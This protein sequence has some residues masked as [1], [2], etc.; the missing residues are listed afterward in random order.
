[1]PISP[2]CRLISWESAL[3]I[4]SAGDCT[5]NVGDDPPCA[6]FHAVDGPLRGLRVVLREAGLVEV[7]HDVLVDDLVR[8]RERPLV[9][10]LVQRVA[11]RA[12]HDRLAQVEVVERRVRG[13][14]QQHAELAATRRRDLVA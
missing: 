10:D 12:L 4:S 2:I 8:E 5:S 6:F 13:V 14:E 7:A 9:R 1:M 3:F 11:V